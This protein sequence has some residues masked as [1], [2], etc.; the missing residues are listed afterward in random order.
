MESMSV[1]CYNT[2]ELCNTGTVYQTLHVR[3]PF[4][5]LIVH[6]KIC[7]LLMKFSKP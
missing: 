2:I 7:V 6:L 5:K 4:I 1:N 3:L